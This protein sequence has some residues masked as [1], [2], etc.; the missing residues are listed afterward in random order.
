MHKNIIKV[1][2]VLT[3]KGITDVREMARKL[4][5][6]VD[7]IESELVEEGEFCKELQ[8]E[9]EALSQELESMKLWQTTNKI[10]NGTV[11]V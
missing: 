5:H 8:S 3:S 1:V 4:K 7:A 6:Q 10:D 2:K 9:E 11:T